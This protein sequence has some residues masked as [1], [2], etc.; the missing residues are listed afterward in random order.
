[1]PDVPESSSR[2]FAVVLASNR[3]VLVVST[4]IVLSEIVPLLSRV[5]EATTLCTVSPF[6]ESMDSQ[7]EPEKLAEVAML[8]IVLT[9]LA[10]SAWILDLS[11]PGCCAVTRSALMEFRL[12]MTEFMP[13]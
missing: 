12:S 9:L 2:P 10:M 13:V 4:S 1:M 5:S 6:E 8:W 3:P 7:L 11:T